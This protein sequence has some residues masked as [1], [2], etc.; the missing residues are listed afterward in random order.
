MQAALDVRRNHL[1]ISRRGIVGWSVQ[2]LVK[3]D[4]SR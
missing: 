4:I 3:D 2:A 1:G